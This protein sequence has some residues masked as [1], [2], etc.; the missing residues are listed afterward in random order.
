MT[1]FARLITPIMQDQIISA[2]T[3]GAGLY[4]SNRKALKE[5]IIVE[6]QNYINAEANWVCSD[7]RFTDGVCMCEISCRTRDGLICHFNGILIQED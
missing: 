4:G 2:P 5:A 6:C 3:H 7:P 1:V